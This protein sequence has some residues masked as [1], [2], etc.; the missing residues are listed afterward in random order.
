MGHKFM[1]ILS[2]YKQKYPFCIQSFKLANDGVFANDRNQNNL[3]SKVLSLPGFE[4]YKNIHLLNYLLE[5]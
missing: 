5:K 1:Y 4:F 2:N 3:Q